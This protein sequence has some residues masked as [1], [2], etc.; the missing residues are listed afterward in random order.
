MTGMDMD[1]GQLQHAIQKHLISI[2]VKPSDPDYVAL[3]D[4]TERRYRNKFMINN[5]SITGTLAGT[6]T[7]NT[8]ITSGMT[9]SMVILPNR[10]QEISMAAKLSFILEGDRDDLDWLLSRID[11]AIADVIAEATEEGRLDGDVEAYTEWD[12]A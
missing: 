12:D 8:S 11:G 5:Y 10:K 7:T 6:V 4:E 2:G 3:Y 9:A 1:D